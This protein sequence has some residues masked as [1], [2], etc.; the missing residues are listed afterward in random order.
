MHFTVKPQR[1]RVLKVFCLNQEKKN[2]A[3]KFPSYCLILNK[4]RVV[5][6]MVKRREN[7]TVHKKFRVLKTQLFQF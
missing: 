4:Y 2:G 5:K 7:E 3:E 1:I 6:E